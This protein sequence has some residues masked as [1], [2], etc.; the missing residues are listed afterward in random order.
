MTWRT[1]MAFAFMV[2]FG[3]VNVY[4]IYEEQVKDEAGRNQIAPSEV[5]AKLIQQDADP[6]LDLLYNKGNRESNLKQFFGKEEKLIKETIDRMRRIEDNSGEAL[7]SHLLNT[8][9]PA[10]L[11]D[12]FCGQ[13]RQIRP[14]YGGLRFLVEEK[15]GDRKP[16]AIKR[17]SGFEKQKWAYVAPVEAIYVEVE[18]AE[19]RMENAT[20][21]AIAGILGQKEQD[22]LERFNPWGRGLTG[23]WSWKAV[24]ETVPGIRDRIIEYFAL[25]HLSVEYATQEEAI[26]GK[27]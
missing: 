22:V 13:T 24:Q 8:E 17:I 19:S 21:M 4:L 26:C 3:M 18:L 25:M 11:A 23:N 9:Y 7:R 14:R 5:Q 15:N 2:I 1:I 6:L 20:L 16:I 27:E 12:A 10:E